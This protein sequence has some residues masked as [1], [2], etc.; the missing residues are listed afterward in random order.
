MSGAYVT[1]RRLD[2]LVRSLSERELAVIGTLDRVRVATG[3]QLERS[4]FP[5]VTRRQTRSVLTSLADRRL[6][7]RLP[8]V[9][10][11]VRAG[12]GGYVYTLDVAGQRLVRPDQVR[13][14]RPWPIGM[15][16]LAHSLAVSELFVRLVEA[17]RAGRLRL[18]SFVTEPACWRSFHGPGGV[19]TVLKPDAALVARLGR[20]EDWWFVEVDR[21]TESRPTLA[22]KFDLYRAF[23]QSGMEQAR[24]GV[25]PR[26]LWLVPDEQRRAAL[27]EIVGRQPGEAWTLFVVTTE[28]QAVDCLLEGAA[29]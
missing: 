23:W 13:R 22:R 7:A 4:C 3:R 9:V 20:F 8:R 18:V 21:G 27:V 24:I 28:T 6:L 1:S 15:S 25:F 2:E 29:P 12:S 11:G 5:D 16:F 14:H 10:G 26:V 19:R 17:E